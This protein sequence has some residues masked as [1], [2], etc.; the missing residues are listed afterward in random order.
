MSVHV[1]S[2][3]TRG[4]VD[5]LLYI[6]DNIFVTEDSSTML[7]EAISSGKKVISI[8]PQNINAPDKYLEIIAKYEGLGFIERCN[9]TNIKEFSLSG[10]IN[11][12]EKV[13]SYRKNFQRLLIDR[14][15]D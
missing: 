8:Y 13:D 2:E 3:I 15:K 5:Q 12:Q 10:E 7:S 9:V 6:A 14:L 11:I 1:H 4:K